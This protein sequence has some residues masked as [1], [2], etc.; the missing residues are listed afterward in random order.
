MFNVYLFFER[1]TKTEHE[2]GKGR[3]RGR[4]RI[5]SR[6]QVPSCQHRAGHKAQAQEPRDYDLGRSQMLN[7]LSH[8]GTPDSTCLKKAYQSGGEWGDG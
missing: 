6:L 2:W 1:E 8:P 5:R 7:Q 4:Y 3:E